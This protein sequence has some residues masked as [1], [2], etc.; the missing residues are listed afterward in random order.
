MRIRRSLLK[1]YHLR[2][3]TVVK[4]DE[5]GSIEGYDAAVPIEAVIWSAGG[6]VQAQMYG[7]KLSYIKNMEY[8]GTEV[9]R[10]GDGICVGVSHEANPD[11]KVISVNDDY[12]PVRITLERM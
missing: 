11:Y 8:E 5:G 2:R 7:E 6:R 4:D 1:P 12:V 10:E 3:R 9:I